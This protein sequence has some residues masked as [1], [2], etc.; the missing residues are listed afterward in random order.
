MGHP[1]V[2]DKEY[3]Y[4][5]QKFNLNGQLLHAYKLEFTHPVTKERLTF[6]APLPDYFEKTLKILE[7]LK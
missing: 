6:T 7:N 1:V 3:G 2:G 5:K 4:K